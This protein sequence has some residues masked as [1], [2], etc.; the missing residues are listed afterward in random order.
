[1]Q[2]NTSQKSLGPGEVTTGTV[3]HEDLNLTHRSTRFSLGQ[4]LCSHVL[5]SPHTST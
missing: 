2:L 3:P 1:M 4:R 5:L